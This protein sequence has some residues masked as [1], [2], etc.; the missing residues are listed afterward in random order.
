MKVV[1]V[2]AHAVPLV[3]LGLISISLSAL[4]VR[5]PPISPQSHPISPQSRPD[6]DLALGAAG[7]LLIH[8]AHARTAHH[9]QD[10]ARRERDGAR[11]L[12]FAHVRLRRL[13]PLTFHGL[14]LA[15]H[16]PPTDLPPAFHWPSTGLPL[17]FH[18]LP[19]AFHWPPS[20][21]PWPST[22]LPLASL[23]PSTQMRLRRI[24]RL[25][26]HGLPLASL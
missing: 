14:P 3:C 23:W 2:L 13:P 9:A 17:T 5:S 16:R 4:Q 10:G 21:L 26:F 18:G 6:L 19:L 24:P 22:G 1:Y 15:F 7:Q 20:D 12:A 8:A 11:P 25:T